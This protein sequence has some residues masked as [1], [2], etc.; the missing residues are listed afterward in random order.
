MVYKEFEHAPNAKLDYGFDW[1]IEGWLSSGEAITV[2]TWETGDLT[3]SSLQNTGTITSV[4]VEG[5]VIGMSYSLINH[6][7][8]STGRKD[9]RTIKLSCKN[10]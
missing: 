9:S 1:Q 5:G 6:I 7:T 8:T 3:P 2:S 10:R 4:F